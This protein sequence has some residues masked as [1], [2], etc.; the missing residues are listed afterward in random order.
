MRILPGTTSLRRR[1]AAALCAALTVT[2]LVSPV[3]SVAQPHAASGDVVADEPTPTTVSSDPLPTVQVDG[4]VWAQAVVGDTVYVGGSFTSARPA[5]AAAGTGEVPR[6]NLLAYDLETG[7]LVTSWSPAANGQVKGLAVAPDGSRLYAVGQFTAIDGTTRYRAAAFDT[8]TG[9]LTSFRPSVNASINAVAVSGDDVFLG[10]IFSTVN[11]IARTRVA[12]VD[13]ATGAVTRP[14]EADVD[15]RSVQALT[16]APDGGSVVVAGNFTSVDGSSAPGFGLARLDAT[17][18]EQ[19]ALPVNTEVRNAGDQAAILSL[20]SDARYLYGSGYHFSGT[21]NVE[22]SFAADW[23]TGELVWLEDCHGD[24]YSV[25]P[26][27]GAVYQASHKHYCGNSAGFPETKPRSYHHGTA[28]TQT[29]HGTN[30]ADIYGYPDHPGTPR[31]EFLNWYPDFTVGTYTGQSQG[32]WHVTAA[33]NYVLYGGEFLRVNNQPQQGLV[34]FAVRDVAP[35]DDGPRV[36]GDSFPVT[37]TSPTGGVARISWPSNHDR[38]DLTLTYSVYRGSTGGQP[39]FTLEH[40]AT[41]WQKDTLSFL[42]TGLAPGSTQRYTVV[43]RDPWGN[44]AW[45][46]STSVVVDDGP[47]PGAYALGVLAEGPA[48]YWRMGGSDGPVLDLAGDTDLT[49]GTAMRFGTAGALA[50][51]ADTAVTTTGRSASRAWTTGTAQAGPETFSVEAW[52]RTTVRGGKLIGFGNRGSS[53]SSSSYDR[54]LYVDGTGRLVFGTYSGAARTVVSPSTVADGGWHHAVGTLG[55]AGLQLYVDGELVAS[56]SETT[57]A[58]RY[59]GYWRVG[60]DTVSGWSPSSPR[61]DFSGDLDEIAVYERALSAGE[62]ARHH[63]LGL[64][65]EAPNEAPS[66]RA[67]FAA[68][69]LTLTADAS[70]SVDPDGE[71]VSYAWD[72]GDGESSEG[73]SVEHAYAE[74]GTYAVKLTVTDDDGAADTVSK[75]VTVTAPPQG[76][77]LA[78]DE[79]GRTVQNGWG[80]ADEGGPWTLTGSPTRFSVDGSAGSFA[81]TG[82]ATLSAALGDVSSSSTELIARTWADQLPSGTTYVSLLGRQAGPASLGGRLKIYTDGRVELHAV[83]SGVP[84]AG[85]QVAGLTFVPGVPLTV[86]VQVVGTAP[87]VIRARVWAEGTPEPASWQVTTTDATPA[88]QGPGAVALSVFTGGSTATRFSFDDLVVSDAG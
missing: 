10:G 59:N 22:G 41:F 34:R 57:G 43:A 4:V 62:I 72:L 52:F 71:V 53:Q 88:L 30:S 37:V 56:R 63:L 27:R 23:D 79:F 35:N 74:A 25:V 2:V 69:G 50:S 51:D 46:G 67:V 28:V 85:G 81:M 36:G 80:N 38:D 75:D 42:D 73:V 17:T 58:D 21:G 55:G 8:A 32:P 19:Q 20:S 7:E 24:T 16:V 87:T 77:V 65:G 47:P 5:G 6:S 26:F 78:H 82:G 40:A 9:A 45:S 68:E 64:T 12:A 11:N 18:G 86:R 31:P 60:G 44:A 33:G 13:A 84:V 76:L 15:N 39:V 83:R 61:Q 49:T 1:A 29:V 66:A 70:G 54:H 48:H 3:V 14:F